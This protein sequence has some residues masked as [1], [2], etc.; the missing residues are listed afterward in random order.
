MK[1]AF[2]A[3]QNLVAFKLANELI[4]RK[5][6]RLL[7]SDFIDLIFPDR[8]VKEIEEQAT[9]NKVDPLVVIS[10]MK[11]E[12]G[13]KAP[14]L[15]SSGALGLMQ[16]MPFTAIDTKKDLYLTTLKDPATNIAVGTKYLGSLLDKYEG[17]IPYA[18]AAYNAGPNRVAKWK[19]EQK[20]DVK[21]DVS[22]IEWIESIP[23]KETRDYVMSILRNRFWYQYRKGV[24]PESIF[25]VWLKP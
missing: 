22:M 6:D 19:R 18:L 14:I 1:F 16:L 23:Y 3:N 15:S 5:Y 8:F 11:Q 25:K 24:Q 17:N 4:Q 21:P 12:S 2:E 9:L 10:L 13:F 7:S 20:A